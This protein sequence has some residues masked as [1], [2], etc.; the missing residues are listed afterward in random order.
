MKIPYLF[1]V[2]SSICL[3]GI[4]AN[5][6]AQGL[7]DG[8]Y[9]G[10]GQST[11]VIGTGY[12]NNPTYLA[13]KNELDL[14]K[15]FFNVNTF[16]AHGITANL[17]V[18][19]TAAYV[20]SDEEQDL[21]DARV[22]FKYRFYTTQLSNFNLSLQLA[23]GLSFP[24]SNYETEGLNAIGQRATSVPTRLL[25]HAQSGRGWFATLQAG[26][27]ARFNPVPSSNNTSLRLGLAA[28]YIYVDAFIDYQNSLN[29]R[30]YRGAPA[31]N[32][33]REL[34]VDFLRT[35]IT[36]YRSFLTNYGIFIN[37]SY[38]IDGRNVGLGPA[39][40]AGLVFK[41]N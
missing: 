16:I 24:L 1:K 38:T 36:I 30:D 19:L 33:F 32:N 3:F 14:E 31:P 40:N 10:A 28:S 39:I 22:I 12:E 35:G 11:I 26:Y 18:N 29:G 5:L 17:D 8:F 15:S 6:D 7:V 21:Q 41:T 25:V 13:G 34:E 27:D 9:T 37:G 20:Q 23:S 2:F 4:L